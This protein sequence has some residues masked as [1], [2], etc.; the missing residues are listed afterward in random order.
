AGE[1]IGPCGP[2][3]S[4]AVCAVDVRG[5]K[6]AEDAPVGVEEEVLPRGSGADGPDQVLATDAGGQLEAL[7]E[8]PGDRRGRHPR[9]TVGRDRQQCLL[10]H[11][12]DRGATRGDGHDAARLRL[13]RTAYG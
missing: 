11:A 12:P 2:S 8:G 7:L 9:A 10:V 3:R 1:A 6:D 5:G 4:G 13:L